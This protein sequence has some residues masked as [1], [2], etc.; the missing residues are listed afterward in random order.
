MCGTRDKGPFT[1]KEKII[2]TT[3]TIP[4]CPLLAALWLPLQGE[5]QD[6]FHDY[7]SLHS[8]PHTAE[9]H[10]EELGQ[11]VYLFYE[12]KMLVN[13]IKISPVQ[14]AEDMLRNVQDTNDAID[15]SL[16]KS[17]QI[18]VRKERTRICAH[19]LDDVEIDVTPGPWELKSPEWKNLAQDSSGSTLSWPI[20]G[21]FQGYCI[22]RQFMMEDCAGPTF[23][24]SFSNVQ[25][26]AFS[27]WCPLVT[28]RIL[29]WTSPTRAPLLPSTNMAAEPLLLGSSA[30]W[31]LTREVLSALSALCHLQTRTA[32]QPLSVTQLMGIPELLEKVSIKAE[33]CKTHA[34]AIAANNL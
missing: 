11:S 1:G 31:S 3:N 19:L 13:A 32:H 25:S 24:I 4:R 2:S 21:P 14:S 8:S 23:M 10:S 17:V 6:I 22:G 16:K 27:T 29:Q 12:E 9:H 18:H 20:Y 33:L 34:I 30:V 28:T 26:G 15:F 5:N 7:Q